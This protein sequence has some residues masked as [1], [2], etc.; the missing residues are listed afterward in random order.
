[1]VKEKMTTKNNV[2]QKCLLQISSPS[3]LVHPISTAN[4]SITDTTIT[5]DMSTSNI[6]SILSTTT[7]RTSTTA[8]SST[9]AKFGSSAF[10]ITNNGEKISSSTKY[11]FNFAEVNDVTPYHAGE[12][13][14]NEIA[15]TSQ[16]D[17]NFL[18]SV[19]GTNSKDNNKEIK[20]A[21][22]YSTTIADYSELY[23]VTPA[24]PLSY[25]MN[26]TEDIYMSSLIS[27]SARDQK[28]GEG[29]YRRFLDIF[30]NICTFGDI[31]RDIKFFVR[32]LKTR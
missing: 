17:E 9:N 20:F 23:V 7:T 4:C 26:F 32:K 5:A 19:F 11:I 24:R 18:N 15:A 27:S 6:T 8:K 12:T 13:E 22:S 1:M 2:D 30:G 25:T 29:Q 10:S 16:P 3:K 14:N 28:T 31:G 21:D